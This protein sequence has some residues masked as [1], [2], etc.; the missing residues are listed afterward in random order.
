M[1][2]VASLYIIPHWPAR[3]VYGTLIGARKVYQ[4]LSKAKRAKFRLHITLLD[5]HPGVLARNLCIIMLLESLRDIDPNTL[6]ATE[7]QAT[8]FYTFVATVM[9]A[10]CYDRYTFKEVVIVL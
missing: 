7:I 4:D 1:L 5:I 8:L 6:V 2:E 9:P 10:Y 3:H